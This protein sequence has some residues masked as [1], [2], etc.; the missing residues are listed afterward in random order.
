MGNKTSSTCNSIPEELH[1]IPLINW[2]VFTSHNSYLKN[3]QHLSIASA[4]NIIKSMDTGA[5]F[6]FLDVY[7]VSGKFV[8]A[9]GVNNTPTTVYVSLEKCLDAIKA[10]AF[11]RT[12]DP[13]LINFELCLASKYFEELSNVIKTKLG[14]S[15]ILPEQLTTDNVWQTPIGLLMNKIAIVECPA[16]SIDVSRNYLTWQNMSSDVFE[17]KL[18]AGTLDPKTYWIST[19]QSD[20]LGALFGYNYDPKPMLQVG[21]QAVTMNVLVNDDDM[22][23]YRNWFNNHGFKLSPIY[24]SN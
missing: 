14:S 21:C 22:S 4:D 13:L 2:Q 18:E 24:S 5:R 9:H 6:L 16:L 1:H 11:E 8:I 10:H 7:R 20:N 12:T 17:S 3:L 23:T 19:W 15:L